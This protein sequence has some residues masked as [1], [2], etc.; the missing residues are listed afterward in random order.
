MITSLCTWPCSRCGVEQGTGREPTVRVCL[1]CQRRDREPSRQQVL[2]Q[3]GCPSGILAVTFESRRIPGGWP[4]DSSGRPEKQAVDLA[5]WTGGRWPT[6]LIRGDVGVGK[7]MLAAELL[8]LASQR[9]TS[10]LWTTGGDYVRWR[11]RDDGTKVFDE[12]GAL[13]VD[14]L[15]R[16]HPGIGAWDV[17]G[18]MIARRY[19][20]QRQTILTSNLRMTTLYERHAALADRLR[21]GLVVAIPGTSQR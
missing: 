1:A 18:S 10:V 11:F 20:R 7:S 15:G 9:Q 16:D 21:A 19:D 3:A 6:L 4:R 14:D 12:I 17:V 2:G 13:V 5:T 8:W